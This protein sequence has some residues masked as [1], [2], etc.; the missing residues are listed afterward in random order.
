MVTTRE[1]LLPRTGTRIRRGA[2][3]PSFHAATDSVA[4]R[5][6]APVRRSVTRTRR[7]LRTEVGETRRDAGAGP[8]G[9]WTVMLTV[10]VFETAPGASVTRK[11]SLSGP[12]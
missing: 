9:A 5:G 12:E 2:N 11:V 3:R 10:A 1:P 8:A 4:G 7:P 6:K